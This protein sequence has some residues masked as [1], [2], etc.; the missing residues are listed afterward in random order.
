[1]GRVN[2]GQSTLEYVIILAAVIGAII[3]VASTVMKPKLQGSYETLGTK[4]QD[5]IE[6][7]DFGSTP[8]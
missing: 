7:V 2:R 1:M 6:S 4:M 5:K 8:K 3:F